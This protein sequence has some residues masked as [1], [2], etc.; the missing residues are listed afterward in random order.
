MKNIELLAKLINLFV[1]SI[2]IWRILAL[3]TI[4]K[5]NLFF[6]LKLNQHW[7]ERNAI[8]LLVLAI[9]KWLRFA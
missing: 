6:F 7:F 9:A 4:A 2:T 3:L 1:A 8:N 5:P